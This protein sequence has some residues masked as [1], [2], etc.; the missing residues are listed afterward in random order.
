MSVT[1]PTLSGVARGTSTQEG[2]KQ[3]RNRTNNTDGMTQRR[4]EVFDTLASRVSSHFCMK[5]KKCAVSLICGKYESLGQTKS[6][7]ER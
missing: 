2:K 5:M 1:Q 6:F 7:S 3:K 4:E